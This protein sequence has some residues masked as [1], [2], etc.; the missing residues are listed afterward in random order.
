[1]SALFE[2]VRKAC[3]S[4]LWSKGVT[5]ARDQKVSIQKRTPTEVTG[6]VK[7]PGFAIAPTATLY[8]EDGE[9]TCDCGDEAAACP[10]VAALAIAWSQS[11]GVT[12]TSEATSDEAPVAS[13]ERRPWNLRYLLSKRDG[14][15]WIE[16]A[17]VSPTGESK[18]MLVSLTDRLARRI[19][20]PPLEPTHEDLLVDRA[21]H[22][23]ARTTL[24]GSISATILEAL[25]RADVWLD[26]QPVRVS[27]AP[28]LPR[29]Y[30][31]DHP[32]G[33]VELVVEAEP[34]VREVVA[35]G[36]VRTESALRPLGALELCGLRMERLPLRRVVGR[37]RLAELVTEVLPTIDRH[38]PVDVRTTRLPGVTRRLKP[39]LALRVVDGDA[40]L[41]VLP[42]LVY[43]EPPVAR[44]EGEAGGRLVFLGKTT[45]VA[46]ERDEAGERALTQRLRDELGL[47]MGRRADLK[48]SQAADFLT[49][50]MRM[51]ERFPGTEG[52][53][54]SRE[55][56]PALTLDGGRFELAFELPGEAGAE[57]AKGAPRRASADAVL[58]AYY[59][60]LG[61]VPLDGGGLA[62]LPM[63]FLAAHGERVEALLAARRPDGTLA[64]Y[65][66]P[67]L[68][69]LASDAGLAA[70]TS[71]LAALAEGFERLPPA[72]VPPDLSASLRGYQERGVAWL[73]FLRGA[74]MGGVLADDM[75]LGK[76]LQ[77][78][79]ALP[80]AG[81]GRSLVVAPKSVL[82]NWASE[83]ARFRPSLKVAVFHGA[84][85][86]LDPHAD[87]T[88]T[89]YGLLRSDVEALAAVRFSVV[90]LDEAQAIKNDSSQSARAAYK[91]DAELKLA[92]T[93]TPVENRLGELWSLFR[94]AVPGLLGARGTFEARYE[95]PI[96]AGDAQA[97]EKLRARIR[98]FLLR[99]TKDVVAPE[100][101]PKTEA[102]LFVELEP[103][104]R[105]VY[106]AVRAATKAD[107]VKRLDEGASTLAVL[108]ALLRLRQ[109]SCHSALVPGQR[110]ETSSKLERLGDALEE[111]AGE[112][113][114]A[115][116]FSQWV[117]LLDLVEP[118]LARRGLTWTRLDGSTKDRK[119]VVDEFQAPGGPMVMLVSLKAGGVGLNLT[120]AEAVFLLDPWWNPAVEEQAADRAHR[121][122][123]DK[124]VIVYRM[125]A[126]DTVEERM[127]ALA[128]KKR[129]LAS[130]ALGEGGRAETLTRED[131]LALLD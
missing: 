113:R 27:G 66:Q 6:R 30:V 119:A 88:L 118:H 67:D 12:A 56:R 117:T 83:L 122:G 50:L 112:G 41:S 4:A 75:G 61:F 95:R 17:L 121:I 106:D 16:R 26:G 130:A 32:S 90:V 128:D 98:P 76:T 46:P 127:L 52:L 65:A 28:V 3:P 77:T 58:R 7:A 15:L 35:P 38:V 8:P 57:G 100:L 22:G 45:D 70:P 74:G 78:I 39:R 116:V 111:L 79:A 102:H 31:V 14:G 85:R 21:L 20:E 36:L 94:F 59:D 73:G 101:P 42:T 72:V 40:T 86:A 84:G 71:D 37:D 96:E 18:P 60:G 97:M 125:V 91:L 68:A 99:R 9:W 104:E 92:L 19:E 29:A 47:V 107:L 89:T 11:G 93:G 10:H 80:A 23:R 103:D 126:K 115:L 44:V 25:E 87:V 55:V 129:A 110:A 49:R 64:P 131:L 5:L 33:G 124:P 105:A 1:M 108:E 24:Q 69:A 82:H 53:V 54:T 48:G 63:G 2:A 109:A 114:R 123:Q 13:D 120:A 51:G 34:S 81:A 43:G 62:A